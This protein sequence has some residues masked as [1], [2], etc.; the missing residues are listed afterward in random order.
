MPNGTAAVRSTEGPRPGKRGRPKGSQNKSK[1]LVPRNLGVKLLQS[2]ERQLSP[3]QFDY[4]KGVV[5]D[6]KP[7][8][9]KNELDTMIALLTRNLYPALVQ[10]MLPVDEGGFGGHMRKDV[11][12]RLKIVSS[13]LNL[14]YNIDKHDEPD[15]DKSD[16]ILTVT[17]K[18][19]FN[20]ERLAILIGRQSDDMERSADGVGRQT[21]EIRALSDTLSERSFDVSG[22]EQGSSDRVL[23]SD[24]D[25]G[26]SLSDHET[27]VQG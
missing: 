4:I 17:A 27:I 3:E 2:M 9:T 12:D 24:S 13:F 25:G 18:R 23:D 14:R 7:I 26:R 11:T 22:S 16:T 1:A 21:N 8:E 19:G 15:S 20:A 5:R 10:E 6:G